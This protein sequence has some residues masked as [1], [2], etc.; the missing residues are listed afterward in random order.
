MIR[1]TYGFS[2][3]KLLESDL[4]IFEGLLLLFDE[5]VVDGHLELELEVLPTPWGGVADEPVL[6]E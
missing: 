5:W 3:A 1:T 6:L 2:F 4:R